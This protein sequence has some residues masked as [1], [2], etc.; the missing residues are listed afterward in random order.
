MVS[1]K[2]LDIKDKVVLKRF[3]TFITKTIDKIVSPLEEDET[4]NVSLF[5]GVRE[6]ISIMIPKSNVQYMFLK[7]YIKT[8]KE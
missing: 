6:L 4:I 2:L 7:D 8:L 3:A 5:N 1:M